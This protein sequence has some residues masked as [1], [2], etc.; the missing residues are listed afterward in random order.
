M[1]A[2]TLA[3][4]LV[5]A[6]A[7]AAFLCY[8]GTFYQTG[9]QYYNDCWRKAHAGDKEPNSPEQAAAWATCDDTAEQTIYGAGF[10]FAGSDEHSLTPAL[11]AVQKACPTA[12]IDP[13]YAVDLIQDTGGPRLLENFAPASVL[14]R[15]VFTDRWPSCRS[16]AAANGVPRLVK[17]DGEWVWEKP[18]LPCQAEQKAEQDATAAAAAKAAAQDAAFRKAIHKYCSDA[19]IKG[20]PFLDL[21]VVAGETPAKAAQAAH[22]ANAPVEP[23]AECGSARNANECADILRKAGKNPFDAFGTVGHEPVYPDEV[24]GSKKDDAKGRFDPSTA[25]PLAP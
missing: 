21:D 8:R 15:R 19:E 22:C 7:L 5:S 25:V 13:S 16:V 20:D 3:L 1:R 18:C 9:A 6:A 14:I 24:K 23:P 11:K 12:L 10:V 2:S 17:R 4:V